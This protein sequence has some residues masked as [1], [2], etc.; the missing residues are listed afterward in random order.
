M[1][2][3]EAVGAVVRDVIQSYRQLPTLFYQIQLKWRDDP[4]PRAGLIRTREFTMLDSYSLDRDEAGLEEQYQAHY[5]AYQRIFERCRLPVMAVLSDS[6]MMGGGYSHE[7]MYLSPIGED[8][9]LICPACGYAANRQI[10]TFQKEHSQTEEMQEKQKVFTPQKKTI[11]ELAAFLE[12]PP[13]RTAKAIFL[14]AEIG[15][16]W[17]L[18]Q[19]VTRGD[20]ELNEAKLSHV[21]HSTR[22]RPASE[23]EIQLSGAVA[24]YASPIGVRNTLVVCD[25]EILALRN[26]AAGANE[27]DYHFLNVNYGRDFSADLVADIV[28]AVEGSA[29]PQCG[30][31]MYMQRGVEVGN[32][33]KLGTFY[34]EKMNLTYLDEHGTVQPVVMGSYGMGLGRLL[35]CIAEE[36]HD[37]KGLSLPASVAPYPLHLIHIKDQDGETR[38]VA[39]ELYQ[40]LEQAGMAVL[41]DDRDASAG[42][43]F[44]DADLLGM[45]YRLTV[46]SRSLSNGG[47]EIKSR[48]N[49][50]IKIIERRQVPAYLKDLKI[51]SQS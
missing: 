11:A 38:Q 30:K 4:R 23:E 7:F 40:E 32:F 42:V 22:M 28:N 29:C 18:V 36:H 2:H 48:V 25:D 51:D 12:I 35:A 16:V 27:R 39:E 31:A 50:D 13:T 34:S 9:I 1:T 8:S 6:G 46:S 14:M 10:A 33:F 47:I 45:P 49:D 44:N 3:E 41:Y 21:I 19:A 20:R 24:G 37:E 26:L 43:K 5:Q 17:Q 15:E